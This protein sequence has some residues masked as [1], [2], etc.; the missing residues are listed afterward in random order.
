L[1]LKGC[2]HVVIEDLPLRLMGCLLPPT[3][4]NSSFSPTL[5]G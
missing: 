3:S 1:T 5:G 2:H 4:E